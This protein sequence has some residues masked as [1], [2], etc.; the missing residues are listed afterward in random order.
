MKILRLI[1]I[2]SLFSSMAEAQTIEDVLSSVASHN[3]ELKA[4][5]QQ[6]Q[7][8]KLE[9][10]TMNKLEDPMVEYGHLWG[11]NSEIKMDFSVTQEFD[12]PT[13][14]FNRHK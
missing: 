4:G 12:F 5:E 10:S 6:L 3:K 7:S 11:R 8:Q 14:Y 13:V 2:I 9:V 1:L